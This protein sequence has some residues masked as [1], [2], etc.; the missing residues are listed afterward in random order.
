M[1]DSVTNGKG[2]NRKDTTEKMPMPDAD[3]WWQEHLLVCIRF[4]DGRIRRYP[5][6]HI[7]Y[8]ETIP[9]K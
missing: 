8:I 5:M 3:F 7:W 9:D 4:K 6:F 1:G 2:F